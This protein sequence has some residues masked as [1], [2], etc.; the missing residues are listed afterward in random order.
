MALYEKWLGAFQHAYRDPDRVSDLTCPNCG[1]QELHLRF[2]YYGSRE[3][4]ANVAFWCGSC[5]QGMPTGPSEVPQSCTPVWHEDAHV[6][7][8]R[9]VAPTRQSERDSDQRP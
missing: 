4:Q 8:Y 5:L 9:I 3:H 1:A 6:P 7:N 2:L